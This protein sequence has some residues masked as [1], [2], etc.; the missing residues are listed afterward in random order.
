MTAKVFISVLLLLASISANAQMRRGV[1]SQIAPT[2]VARNQDHPSSIA[3][4]DRDLYWVC[5]QGL[6][7]KS[8]GRRKALHP[9]VLSQLRRTFLKVAVDSESV[10]FITR[11]EVTRVAKSGGLSPLP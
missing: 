1:P 11:D 10:Y 5:D 2:I 6:P 7:L 3:V 8:S 4:D 9:P